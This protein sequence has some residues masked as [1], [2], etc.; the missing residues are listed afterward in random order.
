MF[1]TWKRVAKRIRTVAKQA[2]GIRVQKQLGYQRGRSRSRKPQIELKCIDVPDFTAAF[3]TPAGA[4]SLSPLLN[5]PKN[6]PELYDRIGRKI[7]MKSLHVRGY[8]WNAAT[9]TQSL[10]R[11]I[12]LYDSQSNGVAPVIADILS[13]M[14]GAPAT[15]GCSHI[16]LNN[17]QRFSILKDHTITLPGCTNVAGVLTNGPQFNDTAPYRYEINWFV[18][19]KGLETIYNNLSAGNIGDVASGALWIL[20]VTDV[21]DATW[22]FKGVARLRYY[23]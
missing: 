23:D 16:N 2:V 5:V 1:R 13:N 6:G 12:L 9:T 10:G 8:V 18:K 4:T 17:R 20:F 11:M 7:Y 14:N 15:T 3:R 19:L 22:N 21:N